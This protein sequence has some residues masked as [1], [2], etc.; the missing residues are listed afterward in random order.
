MYMLRASH[1]SLGHRGGYAAIAL[2][3]LRFWWPDC[4]GDAR[5]YVKT[6]V[7]CQRRHQALYKSPPVVTAT[8]S[9]FQKIHTDV[10]HMSETSNRCGYIVDARCS[11]SR[12]IEARGL[13]SATAETIGRFLLEE[14][15]CRWG[16][17]R[18]LVTDNGKPFLAAVKWL[19]KK[20]GIE[21]IKISAYNS[22]ANGSVERGHWD[23]RQ[24]LFKATDGD[25][26]KWF[27]SSHKYFRQTGLL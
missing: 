23:I 2:I 17:P 10:M 27:G 18:W 13:T 26:K 6:C 12:Y 22:Q 7:A 15:I 21:G 3:G 25:L 8:P 16:C 1:D 5:W 20:Y 24:S 14:V 11:L 4:E 19:N 9:I